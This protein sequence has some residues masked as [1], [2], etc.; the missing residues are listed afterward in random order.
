MPVRAFVDAVLP[1]VLIED[2]DKP[3]VPGWDLTALWTPG[4][5][6]RTPLLLG[7]GRTG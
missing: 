1:D 2:G 4:P 3:D 7:A 5:L 6:A